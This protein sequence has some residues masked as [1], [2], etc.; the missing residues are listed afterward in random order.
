MGKKQRGIEL[1]TN[2][3]F[4]EKNFAVDKNLIK[5]SKE[6]ECRFAPKNVFAENRTWARWK[7]W[8]HKRHLVIFGEGLTK[9]LEWKELKE[10]MNPFWTMGEAKDFVHKL[11]GKALVE[12][13][14]LKTWQFMLILA[15]LFI[16]II[17]LI[18]LNMSLVM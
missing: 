13:K 16:V 14:P 3:T 4:T 7:F 12:V 6:E 8:R 15:F 2:N 11:A 9:A 18:R 1:H 5:P 17:L 10:G